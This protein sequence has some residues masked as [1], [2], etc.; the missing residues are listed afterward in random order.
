MP[1][2]IKN[3][4]KY[5]HK[6]KLGIAKLKERIYDEQKR[7]QR[8]KGIC[9]VTWAASVQGEEECS[10]QSLG[11]FRV[12]DLVVV[13]GRVLEVHE[14]VGNS[15]IRYKQIQTKKVEAI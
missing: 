2:K 4:E 12:G 7:R 14:E 15:K 6:L 11:A 9:M 3:P 13:T 8:Y 10:S 1:K 5:I